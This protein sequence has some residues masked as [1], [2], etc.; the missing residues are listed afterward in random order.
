M[1]YRYPAWLSH[2]RFT[3]IIYETCQPFSTLTQGKKSYEY[4]KIST[5]MSVN[6]TPNRGE[7]FLFDVVSKLVSCSCK[8]F[9]PQGRPHSSD[10][11]GPGFGFTELHRKIPKLPILRDSYLQIEKDDHCKTHISFVYRYNHPDWTKTQ[12]GT[13]AKF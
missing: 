4:P 9:Q 13:A 7:D 12:Y 3:A 2:T 1:N 6:P 11:L 5:T 8:Q 10:Q